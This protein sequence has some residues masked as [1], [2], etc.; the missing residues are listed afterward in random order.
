[1]PGAKCWPEAVWNANGTFIL[2]ANPGFCAWAA[3][4]EEATA[5]TAAIKLAG[6]FNIIE[7]RIVVSPYG[8]RLINRLHLLRRRPGEKGEMKPQNNFKLAAQGQT[9]SRKAA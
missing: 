8:R 4:A 5:R 1:M 3:G 7:L 2:A 9:G 6:T